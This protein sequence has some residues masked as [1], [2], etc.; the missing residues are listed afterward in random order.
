ML[1]TFGWNTHGG[2]LMAVTR[3]S[4]AGKAP[5]VSSYNAK[6]LSAPS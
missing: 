4:H 1:P 3:R 6:V 2:L 5:E